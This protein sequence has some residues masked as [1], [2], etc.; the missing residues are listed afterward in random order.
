VAFFLV[1]EIFPRFFN[2]ALLPDRIWT[3]LAILLLFPL[4]FLV[5]LIEKEIFPP[6]QKHFLFFGLSLSLC[7]GVMGTAYVSSQFQYLSSPEEMQA[8]RW[9]QER[10][11]RDRVLFHFSYGDL[12]S[13]HSKSKVYKLPNDFLQSL[14][15]GSLSE[16]PFSCQLKKDVKQDVYLI[17]D[18]VTHLSLQFDHEKSQ[19]IFLNSPSG[20]ALQD[21]ISRLTDESKALKEVLNNLDILC[22]RPLYIY[23]SYSQEKNPFRERAY[24]TG[25]S[26]ETEHEAVAVLNQYPNMLKLVFQ[27]EGVFIWRV[28]TGTD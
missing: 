16:K 9:I 28:V 7:V 2:I 27:N 18:V 6:W 23:V 1:T 8:F 20:I 22:R 26:F 14:A 24:D 4:F 17:E 11:P 13:Y 19:Y 3:F 25:F 15:S 21:K 10:L 12:L 5:V